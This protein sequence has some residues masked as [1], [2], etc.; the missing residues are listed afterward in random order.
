MSLIQLEFVVTASAAFPN[1]TA[2][3]GTAMAAVV[4][5]RDPYIAFLTQVNNDDTL[6]FLNRTDLLANTSVIT[7]AGRENCS[8][9]GWDPLT[10]QMIMAFPTT[11]SAT[12]TSPDEIVVVST[13]TGTELTALDA[14]RIDFEFLPGVSKKLAPSGLA[15]NAVVIA[16]SGDLW[17]GSGPESTVQFYSRQGTALGSVEFSGRRIRGITAAPWSWAMVDQH[18]HEIVV[19]GPLGTEIAVAPGIGPAG[20]N[21]SGVPKGM[22]AIAFGLPWQSEMDDEPQEWLAGGL[23]GAPGTINHPDTEWTP[24]PWGGRHKLYIANESDQTIY[25]GYLTLAS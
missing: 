23:T 2:G 1:S 8:G 5:Q 24:E 16:R 4:R 17:L 13:N 21:T 18:N 25:C 22:A 12:D 6:F 20:S 3:S 19:L 15:M 10:R 9:M 7:P 14:P 11:T